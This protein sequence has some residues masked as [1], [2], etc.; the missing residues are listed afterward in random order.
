MN[1]GIPM[2]QGGT[3]TLTD[4]DRVAPRIEGGRVSLPNRKTPAEKPIS[5]FRFDEA[6]PKP[7]GGNAS[8]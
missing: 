6:L 1:L 2:N 5:D 8:R 7:S 4:K 3:A